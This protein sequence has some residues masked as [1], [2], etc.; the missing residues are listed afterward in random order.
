MGRAETGHGA[1]WRHKLIMCLKIDN[2][3]R[4]GFV[5]TGWVDGGGTLQF[6]PP[7]GS[8]RSLSLPTSILRFTGQKTDLSTMFHRVRAQTTVLARTRWP[9][10]E[11]VLVPI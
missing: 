2:H 5:E 9:V 3:Y 10:I 6:N 8:R 11:T 7:A 4:A 1:G